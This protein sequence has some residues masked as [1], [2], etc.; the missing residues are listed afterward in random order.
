MSRGYR[1]QSLVTRHNPRPPATLPPCRGARHLLRALSDRGTAHL[2]SDAGPRVRGRVISLPL[3]GMAGGGQFCRVSSHC[4]REAERRRA[5]V[6]RHPPTRLV[7]CDSVTRSR[8]CAT[9]AKSATCHQAAPMS[10]PRLNESESTRAV[11]TVACQ[12]DTCRSDLHRRITGAVVETGA[13]ARA[14]AA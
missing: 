10:V 11:V 9:Q 13:G 2:W 12:R 8:R 1:S 6:P 3:H 4:D 5:G 7:T 14:L